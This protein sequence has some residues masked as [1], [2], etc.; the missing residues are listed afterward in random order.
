MSNTKTD[1]KTDTKIN[2]KTSPYKSGQFPLRGPVAFMTHLENLKVDI[3][4]VQ[5]RLLPQGVAGLYHAQYNY[6]GIAERVP[7]QTEL[8]A[9]IEVLTAKDRAQWE[10]QMTDGLTTVNA[11]RFDLRREIAALKK[12]RLEE[13][14]MKIRTTTQEWEQEREE[15]NSTSN[16][17]KGVGKEAA[18]VFGVSFLATLGVVLGARA[19]SKPEDLR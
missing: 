2:I 4:G 8:R 6:D 18:I 10:Q 17:L 14:M 16:R 11:L 12:V 15:R 3:L 7:S 19:F 1:T 13:R 5:E 9:E